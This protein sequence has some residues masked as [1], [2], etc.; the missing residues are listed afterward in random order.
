MSEKTGD[1]TKTVGQAIDDIIHALTPL[2]HDSRIT[3]IRASCEHLK[4]ALGVKARSTT[5][6]EKPAW[7]GDESM[8]PAAGITIKDIKSLKEQKKPGSANEMAALVAFYLS[9]LAPE[10]VRKKEVSFD[11][12][13]KYFKQAGFPLP[14][15][16]R[17][18]L[19]NAKNAGYLDSIGDGRFALNPVGYNLV[20]HNL[21]RAAGEG[22]RRS[23]KRKTQKTRPKPRQRS[24][25]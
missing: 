6:T 13:I 2:D 24:K 12:E 11:D 9:E 17:M 8:P 5:E 4:I 14:K 10:E 18:L 22:S 20:V 15:K 7:I 23:T 1:S 19:T 3:A 16:P 21:P 25:K